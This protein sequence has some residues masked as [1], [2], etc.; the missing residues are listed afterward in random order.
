MLQVY[1]VEETSSVVFVWFILKLRM[2][3]FVLLFL[4]MIFSDGET[5]RDALVV[6]CKEGMYNKKNK[7]DTLL[8]S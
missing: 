7:R 3:Q 1:G 8:K 6:E 5:W 2:N 4:L